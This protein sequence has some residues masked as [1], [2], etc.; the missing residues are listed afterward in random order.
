MYPNELIDFMEHDFEEHK[1][2]IF[3]CESHV[4]FGQGCKNIYF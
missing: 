1:N 3:K 4:V 2:T